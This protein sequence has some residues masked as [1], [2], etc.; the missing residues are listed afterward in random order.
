MKLFVARHGQTVWNAEERVCGITDVELTDLGYAQAREL[1]ETLS[2]K[3]IDFLLSSPLTRAVRTSAILAD[4]LGIEVVLEDRLK[5]QHYGKFEGT[6]R[7][8]TAFKEAKKQ[9]ANRHEGGESLF[10]VAQRVYNLLDEIQVSYSSANVL[11]ITHGSVSRV[12]HSYFNEMTNEQYG[13]HYMR[14][15][16]YAVYSI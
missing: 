16:E 6:V 9:F 10:Q 3:R 8:S 14:N 5:E 12:I 2:G 13:E 15:G 4:V 1:A 7:H 11:L